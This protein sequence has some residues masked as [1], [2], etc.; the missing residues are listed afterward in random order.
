MTSVRI[1]LVYDNT[2]ARDDL[3]ADWG[4]AAL[5]EAYGHRI[6]FDTGADGDILLSNMSRMRISPE[7]VDEVFISHAHMDHIGGL[8]KFLEVHPVP[9]YIP[10]SCPSPKGALKV[11]R[12]SAPVE[13]HEHIHSTG[14]LAG[15]EQSLAISTGTGVIVIVGCSHPGVGEILRVS[16]SFGRPIALVGGLHGFREFSLLESLEIVC[17]AHCTRH[18]AEIRRLYPE[19]YV[20]GGAGTVLEI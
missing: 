20:P 12:I 5:V 13:I 7:S 10:E 4:F 9:V 1:T 15:I 16:S 17:P 14:E 3:R 6:L 2:S 19:K 18:K 11:V 8:E